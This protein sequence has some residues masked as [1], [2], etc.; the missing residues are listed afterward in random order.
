[1]NLIISGVSIFVWSIQFCYGSIKF[2]S[3]FWWSSH[4]TPSLL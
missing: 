3:Y 2:T 4:R 1:M